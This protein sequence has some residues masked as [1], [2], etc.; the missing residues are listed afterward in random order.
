MDRWFTRKVKSGQKKVNFRVKR[1][2]KE[3]NRA[4]CSIVYICKHI[5]YYT[6]YICFDSE[7]DHS[8]VQTQQIFFLNYDF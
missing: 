7:F 4:V 2:K 5:V 1:F 6:I 8:Y 3:S